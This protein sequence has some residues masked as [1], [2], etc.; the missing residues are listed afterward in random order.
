LALGG[1]G[2][3]SSHPQA[4]PVLGGGEAPAHAWQR[5]H[6]RA[7]T[8]TLVFV[9][10]EMEM[11]FMYPWAVVFVREG[12]KAI[13]EMGMFLAILSIGILYGWREGVFRWQ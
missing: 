2:A 8:M 9:A 3:E 13:A 5:Y 12:L 10:F 4:R 1:G 6:F 7:Y 11:M